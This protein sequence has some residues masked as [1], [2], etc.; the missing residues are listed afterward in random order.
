MISK[1]VQE[2]SVVDSTKSSDLMTSIRSLKLIIINN[3][4]NTMLLIEIQLF[5]T[6]ISA[7]HLNYIHI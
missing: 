7:H 3:C 4:A 1:I 5:S 2:K 6:T